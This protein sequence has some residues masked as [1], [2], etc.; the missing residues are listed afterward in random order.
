M[1]LNTGHRPSIKC[2]FTRKGHQLTLL[3]RINQL[4]LVTLIKTY[5]NIDSGPYL[6][7]ILQNC[8]LLTQMDTLFVNDRQ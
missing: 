5:K 7:K 4:P 1:V 2:P 6:V 3:L 8:P